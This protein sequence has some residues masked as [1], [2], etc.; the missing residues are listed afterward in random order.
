VVRRFLRG[1]ALA[2]AFVVACA[3]S[4]FAQGVQ[5]G[6]LTGTVTDQSNL[7]VPGVTVA[8]SSPAMQGVRDTVTDANGVYSLP[9]LPPGPYTVR[10]ELQGMRTLESMQRVDLGQVARLDAAMQVAAVAEVV[11][12]TAEQPSILSTVQGG[13][14]FRTEEL[15]KQA[16][17]RTLWGLAE[18]A[19]GLTDN[20]P[21]ASQITI[22]GG[23][24]YDNQLLV[25][26]VDVADN[27]FAQPNNL[28]I[29]DAIEE[30]QVLTSGISA[31]FGRFGGGVV[32]AITRS[33]GNAFDG[34]VR[35]NFYSPSWTTRT[36]FEETNNS[37]RAKDI[38]QNYEGTFGGPI[39][40]DRL[41]FFSAGRYQDSSTPA[42]L[43]DT[44]IPFN[45]EV[46]NK[47]GELKFTGTLANNHT[48]LGSYLNN[49]TESLQAA[50]PGST[51]EASG[52]VNR[53][54]PNNLWVI[55][56]RGVLDRSILA[57]LQVSRRK[58]GFRNA[59]G[60]K[61]DVA[62]SPFRTRGVLTGVPANRLYG[63]PY[64]DATDPE[65]RK[66]R[67]VTG[68]VNW[69]LST[70][71]LGSHDIKGGFENFQSSVTGGNSQSATGFVF[72]SDYLVVGGRPA[73]DAQGRV[74]PVFQPGVSRIDNW[75]PTRGAEIRI[76]TNSYYV[77]DRWTAG[78]RLTLDL[79]TRF[80]MVNSEATGDIAAI[81]TKTI[82]PRLGASYDLKGDGR[83]IAQATYSHYAGKYTEAIF[84]ENTDVANPSLVQYQYTGP[85]GQGRDFAPGLIPAN[86]TQLIGG[87]FPTANV[88]FDD[89]MHSPV[90][91]EFTLAL[92]TPLGR[93]GALKA[94]YQRRAIGGF[95]EDFIDDP[96]PSGKTT[97]IRDGR[98]FGT[99]DNITWRN[100]DLPKREYQ[101]L[102][103]LGNRRMTDRWTIDGHWTVQLR[104][105]GTFEGEAA[106]QPG[107]PTIIADYPELYDLNRSNPDGRFN[108]FQRHK[109]RLWTTYTQTLGPVGAVD[110]GVIY[111][112]NSPLTYSLFASGVPVTAI[113]NARNPGYANYPVSQTVYFD[114]RGTEEFESAQLVDFALTYSVPVFKDLRPWVKLELYNMFNEQNLVGHNV[115]V[116]P[117]PGGPVDANGLPLEYVEGAQFGRPTSNASFPRSALNFAG[118]NLN[119]RTF[120]L[121]AGF[122]F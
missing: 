34:T 44:A 101:A 14:N 46:T 122:R 92:G 19:P 51:I 38:Q 15:A 50:A 3:A 22:A 115:A 61:T 2:L 91:K 39:V 107:I 87:S 95:I 16:V 1:P 43:P 55:S 59:G 103:F 85:A 97:V 75:L 117:R 121:S 98:N 26:G 57:N 86:Y 120:L 119:A 111:R 30:V 118:Q 7:V 77:H 96:S 27:M 5:T 36:P 84:A 94:M 100:S 68:S 52:V 13:A 58:F 80:E 62:D 105:E 41:W 113:Q 109:L 83:W 10:F 48:L 106:S 8:A 64:F 66:N 78:D 116:S 17:P 88:F 42:P 63:E 90:T 28:F 93:R 65:D 25:N 35:L 99:F 11:Q 60:T 67:Q 72:R 6:T 12:V 56:Y 37:T 104:N 45:T 76:T 4:V 18:L 74:I 47:R 21:N 69:F 79:G 54:T 53:Q 71:R 31:E 9:G 40:R 110:A 32:N 112:Y 81:D 114:E 73:L 23:F 102:V 24:A 108:D 29:E 20:T 82:V 89:G 70:D 49:S 33:G